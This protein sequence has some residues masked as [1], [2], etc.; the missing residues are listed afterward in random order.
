[1]TKKPI[2]ET[3]FYSGNQGEGFTCN[4]DE[5][6]GLEDRGDF[7]LGNEVLTLLK[8]TTLEGFFDFPHRFEGFNCKTGMV[9]FCGYENDLFGGTRYFKVIHL[10]TPKRIFVMYTPK[11]GRDYNFI[12]GVWK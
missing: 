3:L 7:K 10:L 1:M 6:L 5:T 11:S 8:E 4:P 12:N 2:H 9:F